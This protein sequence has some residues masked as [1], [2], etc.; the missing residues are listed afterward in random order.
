[1]TFTEPLEISPLCDFTFDFFT[2]IQNNTELFE[3]MPKILN[4]IQSQYQ[5]QKET[6]TEQE[7][8]VFFKEPLDNF[9]VS[10]QTDHLAQ[11]TEQTG[12]YY[13]STAFEVLNANYQ[14][15][16][17]DLQIPKLPIYSTKNVSDIF[18]SWASPSQVQ[19]PD[20]VDYKKKSK[21][22]KAETSKQKLKKKKV[23]VLS[24]EI[25]P[26][27]VKNYSKSKFRTHAVKNCSNE[28]CP[29]GQ[30]FTTYK[31][32]KEFAPKFQTIR[33]KNTK[34][35]CDSYIKYFLGGKWL[36][37]GSVSGHLNKKKAL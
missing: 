22:R 26:A 37:S 30:H 8:D 29:V 11:F 18:P 17:F 15:S 14:L 33:K 31:E 6:K 5:I 13:P 20:Q 24:E 32:A 10:S 21:K 35:L 16:N 19:N 2:E 23:E 28:N 7:F 34:C 1:M 4:T 36:G 12:T 3:N 9:S 27:E 25:V